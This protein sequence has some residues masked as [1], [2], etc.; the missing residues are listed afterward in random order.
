MLADLESAEGGSIPPRDIPT[1]GKA[2]AG[3]C[4]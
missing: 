2:Y 4:W 3:M 1:S